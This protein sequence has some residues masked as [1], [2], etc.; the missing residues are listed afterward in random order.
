MDANFRNPYSTPSVKMDRLQ[1]KI[2]GVTQPAQTPKKEKK[3]EA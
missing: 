2:P 1:V 3:S